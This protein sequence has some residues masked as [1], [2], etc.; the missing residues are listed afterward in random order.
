MGKQDRE[1]QA[2]EF[3]DRRKKLK[4]SFGWSAGF[5]LASVYG[6]MEIIFFAGFC[7][8]MSKVL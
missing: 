2:K 3:E 7:D 1:R 8:S 4:H 5:V 6:V